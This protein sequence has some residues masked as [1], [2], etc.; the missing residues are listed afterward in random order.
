M[1]KVR[2]RVTWPTRADSPMTDETE[3][4]KSF[5]LIRPDGW[6]VNRK[7]RKIMFLEFKRTSDAA[8]TYFQDMWKV[9]EKQHTPILTGLR[10]LTEERGWEVDVI[11]LVVGRRSVREE[12]WLESLRIFGIGKEDGKRIIGRLGHT[13]LNEHEKLFGSYWWHTFGSSSS[14]S[15]LMG[16]DIPVRASRTPQGS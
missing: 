16:K 4:E 7:M 11:P 8:E 6:V 13:L 15:Q 9:E 3:V 5:C 1:E 12:G 10:A 2:G 14:L